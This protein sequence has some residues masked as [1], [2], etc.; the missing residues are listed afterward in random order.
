MIPRRAALLALLAS[1]SV[2]LVPSSS[3]A[4][5]TVRALT[6]LIAVGFLLR[7]RARIGTASALLLSG[8]LLIGVT[9]GVVATVQTITTGRPSPPG[10][11]ADWLYL[12]YVPLCIAG[13]MRLP[14]D[15]SRGIWR[16]A[17][18]ADGVVAISAGL[19]VVTSLLP[20]LSVVTTG[21]LQGDLA[22]GTYPVAAVL[23]IA[24][25]LGVLPRLRA[26]LRTFAR[27]TGFGL[28][29]LM[30]SDVGYAVATLHGWYSPTTWIAGSSQ[31]GLLLLAAAPALALPDSPRVPKGPPTLLETGAPYFPLVPAIGMG[32]LALVE[33]RPFTLVQTGI[34]LVVA[35]A[36]IV[37][38]I[39]SN[40]AQRSTIS[41]LVAS[42][43]SARA[44]AA[45][46]P[47]TLLANRTRL[48]EQLDELLQAPGAPVLLALLDLD[49][50]KDINDT[51]GHDT[52]DRVLWEIARRLE[53]SAPQ[54]AVIA[55]LG[56]DEFGVCLRTTNPPQAL[57]QAL[58]EAFA[59]P[60]AVG[61]RRFT[62]TAS[63]GV[64]VVDAGAATAFSHA[65]VAMYQAKAGKSPLRSGVM[66]LTGP[67]RDKAA[68]RVQL[69]EDVSHPD[70]SQFRVVYEP[71]VD[72]RTGDVVGAEALLRWRHPDLGDIPPAEFIPLA[73]QVGAIHELGTF[74]LEQALAAA[75]SWT[76]G[77]SREVLIGV[78]LSPRQLDQPE[79]VNVV[80]RLLQRHAL[81]P[82]S[83]VLEITEEALL[84]DWATAVDVVKGLRALGVG[85][86]VDDLGTGY[87]S[88]RYLR[89]FDTTTVKL[90]REFV[91]AQPDEPRTAALVASVLA[92]AHSLGQT[93]VAEG[94]ETLDQLTLVRSQGCALGQG[95]LFDKPMEAV[96]FRE[97]LRAGHRYPLGGL[98]V[99]Q[100][101]ANP[102]LSVIPRPTG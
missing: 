93:T 88:L 48:H 77:T 35:A 50:F 38:Q 39:V 6:A 59:A 51:H 42:E 98:P 89:R 36:M 101:R 80:S 46:D 99:P 2:W 92:M 72:L 28:V 67:A 13:L 61:A 70:L 71:M 23:V 97:L 44:A 86:A 53:R 30:V 3:T 65:D 1:S 78:N 40:A 43:R 69:R 27:L 20:D 29:A 100:P 63:V 45:R 9:S 21:S 41:A 18:V 49:D 4:S 17:A 82:A 14:R 55:R 54:G 34:G 64:V 10:A 11:A 47:L 16:L 22:V 91:Q 58:V 84:D 96:T 12:T 62:V 76:S 57:G 102:S 85:V 26:D 66:V 81:R 90:D 24:V 94:I 32:G 25:V 7:A 75:A 31:A 87:S 74:A 8:S 73:E 52:G 79:M 83:L 37:R 60:V 95:Y 68:A 19:F 15:R 56:G 5:Y 33:G